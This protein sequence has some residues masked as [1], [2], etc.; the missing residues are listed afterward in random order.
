M[1]YMLRNN[2]FIDRK[3]KKAS[4]QRLCVFI[5]AVF[6]FL[7]FIYITPTVQKAK[8]IYHSSQLTKICTKD[9][10]TER[11][12][13]KDSRGVLT[14]AA[15]LG[16][17]T[18]VVSKKDSTR[19]ERYYDEKGKP[20]SRSD[21]YYAVLREYNEK[22]NNIRNTYLDDK[23]NPL[24]MKS[25]YAIQERTF[26]ENNKVISIKYYDAEGKPVCTASYGYEQ[27]YEY[28]ENG[29]NNKI[30][31]CDNSGNP[32]IT[33]L[34][35]AFVLRNFYTT[36]GPENG[37]VESEFYFDEE[38][39]PMPLSLGQYGVHKEYNDVGK[40]SKL[41][42]LDATGNPMVTNKGYSSVERTY[43]ANN[44]IATELYYDL[45]GNPF[46]L[47]EGQYGIKQID[48]QTNYLDKNGKEIFNLKNLLYNH[49]WIVILISIV[50]VVLS[51]MLSRRWNV[52]L[53]CLYI[54]I[55]VYFTLMFRDGDGKKNVE[56]LG[57][58]KRIFESSEARADIIKNIWLFIPLGAI[59]YHIYPQKI[60]LFM[61]LIL[62][63]FIEMTQY[64]TC[65]GFCELD[66]IISNTLGGFIGFIFGKLT[67]DL[68]QRINKRK[69]LFSL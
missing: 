10:E 41:S 34:G 42:Y 20:I 3:Y 21:G 43:Q 38:G 64:F 50:V 53:G 31:Y 29:N 26:N 8:S 57:Y 16:Y 33:R 52:I 25:G 5:L 27:I 60:I 66:D 9:E 17:A 23:D 36:E 39:N 48:G 67:T 12:E 37:K 2:N 1:A 35:Y 14:I 68:K 11:T 4:A 15:D 58:Y 47:S 59:I 44:Y 30:I 65:T 18:M 19:L 61:P 45:E 24:I 32:M 63:I 6:T 56:F 13:Y 28:D 54:F 69:H 40:E 22:G 7:S 62:S 51:M 49:S 55:I 46:S